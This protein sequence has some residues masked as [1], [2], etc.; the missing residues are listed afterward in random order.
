ML[1]NWILTLF[2][3]THTQTHSHTNAIVL[4]YI[5][6]SGATWSYPITN[7]TPQRPFN[8]A[9]GNLIELSAQTYPLTI[10]FTN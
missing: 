10:Q 7:Q 1:Y 9:F 6:P 4:G 8:A 5:K 2:L 3:L